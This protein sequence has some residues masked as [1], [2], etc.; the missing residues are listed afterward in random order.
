[1]GPSSLPRT[2][3]CWPGS[4]PPANTLFSAS[5]SVKMPISRLA[6]MT[7]KAPT[8]LAVIKRTHSV[9]RVSGPTEC[10]ALPSFEYLVQW[11]V[12]LVSRSHEVNAGDDDDHKCNEHIHLYLAKKSRQKLFLR[13]SKRCGRKECETNSDTTICKEAF[14]SRCSSQQNPKF[15]KQQNVFN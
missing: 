15:G 2:L 13:S 8:L 1:M 9:T 14:S 5:R 11:S 3:S 10:I 6:S 7:I 4:R 12:A